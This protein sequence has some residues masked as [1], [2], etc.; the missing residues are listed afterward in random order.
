MNG[1]RVTMEYG[2]RGVNERIEEMLAGLASGT[3]APLPAVVSK[4]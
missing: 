2:Q 1:V 3:G 4:T